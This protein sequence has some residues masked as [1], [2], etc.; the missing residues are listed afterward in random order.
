MNA[1]TNFACALVVAVLLL[2]SPM[3]ACA[4]AAEPPNPAA[5]PCCPS[6]SAP[7]PD[8]CADSACVC[9]DGQP[10]QTPAQSLA[11]PVQTLGAPSDAF[12]IPTYLT[13]PGCAYCPRASQLR[14]A[15]FIVLH[16]LLI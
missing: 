1:T 9:L 7:A 8:E 15:R 12:T 14:A 11:N 3:G 4:G 10:L 6:E 16:Q 5:H 2:F 13:V